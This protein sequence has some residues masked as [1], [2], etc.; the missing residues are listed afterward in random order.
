MAGF[1]RL[2]PQYD[3]L[4]LGGGHAGLQAGF[5]AGLLHQTALILDRGPKFGRSYYAPNM[6]NIPGFPEGISGHKLLDLQLEQVR[7][8]SNWTDYLSPVV[9]HSVERGSEGFTVTFERLRQVQRVT[10]RVLVLAMGV[11]DRIPEVQ[12]E[13]RPIFPWANQGIVDFCVLCDGHTL[14][15]KRVAVI[16]AGKFAALTA[17]D[18]FHFHPT[19]VTIL[20]HG[21]TWLEDTPPEERREIERRL[22]SR[23]VR[24]LDPSIV[25]FEGIREKQF[26]VV[27]ADGSHMTF[28]KGFSGMGWYSTHAELPRKLGAKITDDGY[29]ATDDDCRV[30]ATD[31]S[32]PVP[33]LYAVGDL[34]DGWKQ[35]PEA[36]AT[37]ERAV[38][39]AFA[40]YLEEAGEELTLEP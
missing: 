20:A 39:H 24:H 18:L 38:I 21:S 19:S 27:L 14:P 40:F 7:R 4:V 15:G 37:A 26:G 34:R 13:I 23:G 31:G 32:G 9:V 1:V 30:L 29:V 5:K 12:G 10:G 28:D 3:V 11:V 22:A 8:V 16:G 35:I 2:K 17:L 25:S 33:G 36:W 6:A